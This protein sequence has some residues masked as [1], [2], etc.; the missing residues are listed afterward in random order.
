MPNFIKNASY[1]SISIETKGYGGPQ[2]T[3]LG[4]LK[5]PQLNNQ[6]ID[7]PFGSSNSRD[8]LIGKFQLPICRHGREKKTVSENQESKIRHGSAAIRRAGHM[9]GDRPLTRGQIP[10]TN[11][12]WGPSNFQGGGWRRK[13][14]QEVG[15][16]TKNSNTSFYKKRWSHLLDDAATRTAMVAA[17]RALTLVSCSEAL[18][19]GL[20]RRF[21]EEICTEI[22]GTKVWCRFPLDAF[23]GT[24][25]WR[26]V[27][28]LVRIDAAVCLCWLESASARQ[29]LQK[30]ILLYCSN[31]EVYLTPS[32]D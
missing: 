30:I 6:I 31:C 10:W 7:A 28:A 21:E 11:G 32:Q 25:F 4:D 3:C 9:R 2:P 12:V 17:L 1:R 18:P 13:G 27:W 16:A 20:Q 29:G 22:Q 23:S 26:N 19:C 8:I 15:R 24:S 5:C 14:T